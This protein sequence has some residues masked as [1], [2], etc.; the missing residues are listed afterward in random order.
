MRY[1]PLFLNLA[2]LRVLIAGAGEVGC[3][4]AADVLAC[5]PK[6]MLW[7]DPAVALGGLPADLRDNPALVYEQREAE[8]ADVTGCALVFAA[9]GSRETNLAIAEAAAKRGVPC[10]VIDA[11]QEGNFIVPSHFTDG[12]FTLAVST[13]GSSPAMAKIMR[14]ELQ[15][16]YAGRYRGLLAFLGRLRPKVLALGWPTERNTKLFRSIALSGLGAALGRADTNE[17]REILLKLLPPELCGNIEDL[18]HGLN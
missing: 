10:N 8:A 12:T 1:Y 16:W 5:S 4:K 2:N 3:R 17:A 15:E 6:E 7:L 18:L 11:P 9:T 13:G 14:R